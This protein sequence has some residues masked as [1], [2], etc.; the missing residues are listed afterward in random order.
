MTRLTSGSP[1]RGNRSR[2]V[3]SASAKDCS[4]GLVDPE[5]GQEAKNARVAP[6]V[7][8][9]LVVPAAGEVVEQLAMLELPLH[10]GAREVVHDGGELAEVAEQQEL[11]FPVH[12]DAGDVVPQPRVQLRDLFRHQPVDVAVPVPDGAPHPVVSRLRLHAEV[13][14][15]GVG[16]RDDLDL[17]PFFP[18]GGHDLARQ[19]GFP[20]A[21]VA[22]QQQAFAFEAVEHGVPRDL[23]V[24]CAAIIRTLGLDSGDPV[25]A[26]EALDLLAPVHGRAVG[27]FLADQAVHEAL[28]LFGQVLED[29]AVRFN[30]L[31]VPRRHGG[32]RVPDA[33]DRD[34]LQCH[35][36][37]VHGSTAPVGQQLRHVDVVPV[38]PAR[39]VQEQLP[40][41]AAG[42]VELVVAGAH[43]VD[44]VHV[45]RPEPHEGVHRQL[46]VVLLSLR[47]GRLHLLQG[48][49]HG[50]LVHVRRGVQA[51]HEVVPGRDALFKH[52]GGRGL[53]VPA[54]AHVGEPREGRP[55]PVLRE[56]HVGQ[57]RQVP[58]ASWLHVVLGAEDGCRELGMGQGVLAAPDHVY[59]VADP[60]R[61]VAV[62]LED[63]RGQPGR[64]HVGLVSPPA[65]AGLQRRGVR[66]LQGR[67]VPVA[68]E[69]Q[70]L[71]ILGL[72]GEGLV[73]GNDV[74]QLARGCGDGGSAQLALMV[75]LREQGL[76]RSRRIPAR[77]E[78]GEG[79]PRSPRPPGAARDRGAPAGPSRPA[80]PP[81]PRGKRR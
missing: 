72:R 1:C 56:L 69:A 45:A 78:K 12:G 49:G 16:L 50:L 20:G 30:R 36:E 28:E 53:G 19:V 24:R 17:V 43:G 55:A 67:F 80:A 3:W 13:L 21:R 29:D 71:E 6:H 76:P 11:D 42:A 60:L 14:H 22:R 37:V 33:A 10:R 73:H 23:P 40:V 66:E 26:L 59:S 8:R 68:L 77:L 9:E 51:P 81:G 70:G 75:L 62:E 47:P 64:F 38:H 74:V 57:V 65:E 2:A 44:E 34:V 4:R 18:E 25:L 61:L 32:E 46:R 52:V 35:H 63:Q 48:L 5:P 7:L 27:V 79:R 15:G 39:G 54:F 41:L 31:Q 58:L